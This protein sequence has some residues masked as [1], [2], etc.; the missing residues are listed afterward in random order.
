ML[1]TKILLVD[2]AA[3]MR[4]I[5][6]KSLNAL[7][8]TDI[9]EAE[10]G[11]EAV[12]ILKKGIRFDLIISDWDM[13]NLTGY[14][15][16]KWVRNEY[17]DHSIPFI[18]AT[19]RG[20]KKEINLAKEAGVTGF[21]SK[22]FDDDE[23]DKKLASALG[24][25]I[26]EE[27]RPKS[28]R[29]LDS[30]KL[31]IKAAHIQ[32]TDHLLLGIAKDMLAKGKYN[33]DKFELETVCY[34]GWNPLAESLDKGEVDIAFIL[35][36]LAMDLYASG[37]PI[38]LLTFA[39][40]RGSICVR[41]HKRGSGAKESPADF[42]ADS[43]FLI[44]HRLSIHHMLANMFFRQN[45][46]RSGKAGDKNIDVTF[47]VVP[48]AKM[49]DTLKDNPK[50]SGFLVAEPIGTYAVNSGKAKREFLSN[51][52]WK[53]HPCC[54]VV[55]RNSLLEKNPEAV[56]QLVD[57]FT[58]AS[59]YYE[60]MPLNEAASLALEFLYPQ[61]ELSITRSNLEEI[62]SDPDNITFSGIYPNEADLDRIQHYMH[63]IMQIGSIIDLTKF[64]DYKYIDKAFKKM[65]I[66][67]EKTTE[68]S[69]PLKEKQSFEEFEDEDTQKDLYMSFKSD[70]L[71]YALSIEYVLE[72]IGMQN[73]TEIPNI[74]PYVKGV[75]NLRGK[76]TPII[77]LKKR[78]GLEET[79]YDEKTCI[80][81]V[82]YEEKILG[83]IVDEI[84]EVISISEENIERSRKIVKSEKDKF[85]SGI[86]K[87]PGGIKIIL[88][89]QAL[90][91][92]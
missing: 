12:E 17:S 66:E 41:N 88:D 22:P 58:A 78:F 7:G 14:E 15:L 10:D 83:I 87:I 16:L 11:A 20:E 47:E 21:I 33:A 85:I 75:I 46:L 13:P 76:I 23:L 55:A 8:I 89:L 52:L 26:S 27:E 5:E 3:L 84:D 61:R 51:Q 67:P 90:L 45:G 79:P 92:K 77:D 72:I 68:S 71:S 19:A 4:R 9:T 53:D 29:K 48:P 60:K 49:P 56:E 6:I 50:V 80:V 35:A 91:S 38:S 31:H 59:K 18:M 70:S 86:G 54:V 40:R 62:L 24:M 63:D 69:L 65:N 39:H 57:L 82:S 73:V 64:V 34:S 36:P 44:P 1:K 42:Y 25:E 74:E 2:D 32:I 28:R 30:G 43:T 81:I 37:T